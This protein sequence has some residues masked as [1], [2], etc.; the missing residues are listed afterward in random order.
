MT[1]VP[2]AP[3]RSADRFAPVDATIARL[4]HLSAGRGH[5]AYR[6]IPWDEPGNELGPDDP[7]LVLPSSEP[8]TR[9]AWYAGLSDAD[10]ARV[11]AWK[12]ACSLRVGADFENL[13]QQA[14]LSRALTLPLGV[15]EFRYLHHEVSEES[16]HTMMFHEIA[17]RLGVPAPGMPWW[18]RKLVEMTIPAVARHDPPGFFLTVLAGED[19]VDRMQRR[20]LAEGVAHPIV[21][22]VLRIHVTEESR[23]VSYARMSVQRD[24]PRLGPVRRQV[25]AITAP[26]TFG[27]AARL[28]FVPPPAMARA[29]GV[30]WK[31]LRTAYESPEGRAFLADSCAKPRKLVADVGLMTP[32]GKAM[33]RWLG[34]GG[35][36]TERRGRRRT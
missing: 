20:W 36:E 29:F 13:L 19:P 8:L 18:L 7:R 10:K 16:E 22:Q 26:L 5:E 24:T 9:T 23:H 27:F 3:G 33:W 30:P 31:T 12:L 25:L 4:N 28:M 6:D 21:E 17:H 11:G 1:A 34:I 2:T 35:P 32:A 14:L 15:P